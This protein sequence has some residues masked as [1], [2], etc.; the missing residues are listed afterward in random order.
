[1]ARFNG[2]WKTWPTPFAYAAGFDEETGAYEGVLDGR[3]LMPGLLDR[4]L[5]VRREAIPQEES[6]PEPSRPGGE[7]DTPP[8]PTPPD[9]RGSGDAPAPEPRP[10]RFFASLEIDPERAGLDVARIMDGLLVE[11]TRASGSRLRLHLEIE[12]TADNGGYPKDVVDTVKANAR[13]LRL[14]ENSLGF[15]E[16]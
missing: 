11:L 9:P 8:D 5:L 16:K 2:W 13:D 14:D 7:A 3:S 12:G 10:K 4:G 6:Q 1:M 15:E